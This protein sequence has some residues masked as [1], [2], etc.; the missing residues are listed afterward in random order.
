MTIFTNS[1]LKLNYYFKKGPK[2]NIKSQ[3]IRNYE[4]FGKCKTA[5]GEIGNIQFSVYSRTKSTFPIN[6]Y[7]SLFYLHE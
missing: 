4:N 1:D 2:I 5:P 7:E 3:L 6:L